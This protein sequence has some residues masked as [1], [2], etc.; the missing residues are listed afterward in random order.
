MLYGDIDGRSGPTVLE[1]WE[2]EDLSNY[3][4]DTSSFEV[5]STNNLEGSEAVEAT[6][7]YG[8]IARDATDITTRGNKYKCRLYSP[9][10]GNNKWFCVGSQYAD[11][12][13]FDDTY[14]V[15][16]DIGNNTFKIQERSGNDSVNTTQTNVT[17]STGTEY[18][19]EFEY[20]ETGVS[21]NIVG[22]LYDSNDSTVAGPLTFTSDGFTGGTYGWYA[23][24][25]SGDYWDYVTEESL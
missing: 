21:D 4:G 24:N 7:A 22:T 3:K 25:T 17:L 14:L 20:R 8:D 16:V 6:S 11:S 1:D 23:G 13:T 5:S 10:G 18:R 19:L 2:G 12:S 15:G 9:N